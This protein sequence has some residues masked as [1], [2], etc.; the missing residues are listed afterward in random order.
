[1]LQSFDPS[2]SSR[3]LDDFLRDIDGDQRF[4][5][6]SCFFVRSNKFTAFFYVHPNLNR[7]IFDNYDYVFFLCFIIIYFIT[8]FTFNF[9]LKKQ[10]VS[11]LIILLLFCVIEFPPPCR[12]CQRSFDTDGDNGITFTEFLDWCPGGSIVSMFYMWSSLICLT[13]YRSIPQKVL[14]FTLSSLRVLQWLSNA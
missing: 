13:I 7:C 1:M 9:P 11:Y 8:F 6:G 12:S 14:F 5:S 10:T 3:A 2:V 4:P